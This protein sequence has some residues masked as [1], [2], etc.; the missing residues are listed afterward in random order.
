MRLGKDSSDHWR[1]GHDATDGLYMSGVCAGVVNGCNYPRP[2]AAGKLWGAQDS[3]KA[4]VWR[5]NEATGIP[6]FPLATKRPR[7]WVS[8][9]AAALSRVD[10]AQ[11]VQSEQQINSGP[12]VY[13]MRCADNAAGVFEFAV[14]FYGAKWD[15]SALKLRLFGTHGTTESITWASDVKAM[16]RGLGDVVNNT[17]SATVNVDVTITTAFARV[18]SG[19][20][21]LTPNGT[22]AAD[23]KVYFHGV[24]D[25]TAMSA[26]AATFNVEEIQI[27]YLVSGE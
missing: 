11:C 12:T 26:N 10:G 25:A 4:W 14:N 3:T 16:C 15:G 9:P 17:W 23:D 19:E 20:V 27:G 22:C 1:I 21:D 18:A 5:I 8:V 24:I 13:V 6:E 2:L 7:K